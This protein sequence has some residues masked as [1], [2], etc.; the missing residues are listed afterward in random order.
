MVFPEKIYPADVARKAA[1]TMNESATIKTTP[2]ADVLKDAHEQIMKYREMAK[3]EMVN[4]REQLDFWTAQFEYID[5]YLAGDQR[6][7]TEG[8]D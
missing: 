6:P 4:A 1:E 2:A 5:G 7:V 8:E 3:A